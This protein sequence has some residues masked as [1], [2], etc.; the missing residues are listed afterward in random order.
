[1]FLILSKLLPALLSPAS[2]ICILSLVTGILALRRK[3]KDTA[4]LAFLSFFILY[5][6]ASPITKWILLR[7]LERQYTEPESYPQA[8]AIVVLGGAMLPDYPPR[9][10]PETNAS[11]DRFLQAGRLWR[12]NLA[13]Q[14]VVTGGNISFLNGSERDDA[15]L[16]AELLEELFDVPDSCLL[17]ISKS[18]T[19]YE[20]AFY[21][22]RLFDSLGIKKEILLVTSAQ[23]MPR[24]VGLFCKQGFK[25]IPAPTDYRVTDRFIFTPFQLIPSEAALSETVDALHEYIGWLVY[26]LMGRL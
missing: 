12:E 4:T 7:G 3:A 11:G 2:L 15:S 17:R 22:A 16:Y 13:P 8:S 20:D 23:H 25:V 9:R 5:A 6:A 19:T 10:H 24:S 26:R 1:M 18:Q 14:M 21:C